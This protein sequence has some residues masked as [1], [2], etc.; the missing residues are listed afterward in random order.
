MF[1]HAISCPADVCLQSS[2]SA[3]LSAVLCSSSFLSFQRKAPE[4]F[5]SL[6][7]FFTS[8]KNAKSCHPGI[9]VEELVQDI[10]QEAVVVQSAGGRDEGIRDEV[11]RA[12]AQRGADPGR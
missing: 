3:L 4:H 5:R 2:E 10:Y 11:R 1:L 8:C 9:K 6:H 7:L 12:L